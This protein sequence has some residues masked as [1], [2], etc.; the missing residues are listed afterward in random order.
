MYILPIVRPNHGDIALSITRLSLYRRTIYHTVVRYAIVCCTRQCCLH[1]TR[2][3]NYVL[4]T[5]SLV[6]ATI[7]IDR[8]L[9]VSRTC[10]FQ[11]SLSCI[12]VN[13]MSD[14]PC[15]SSRARTEWKL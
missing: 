14:S 2:A 11:L 4:S 15:I 6:D 1:A 7:R 13:G 5:N 10:H 3:Y 9:C 12:R 8:W